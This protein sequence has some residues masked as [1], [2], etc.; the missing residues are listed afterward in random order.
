MPR[1]AHAIIVFVMKTDRLEVKICGLTR[2]EDVAVAVESG[3]DYLGLIRAAS[4]RA[5]PTSQLAAL[6]AAAQTPVQ[7][8]T[9]KQATAVLL[10]VDAPL[11]T[12]REEL[13]LSGAR[14]VQLH[15]NE[16][17]EL[18]AKLREAAPEVTRI[19][20]LAFDGHCSLEAFSQVARAYVEVA[21]VVLVDA[22]KGGE[23]PGS[24]AL[25]AAAQTLVALGGFRVWLAGGL[26][27]ENLSQ[28]VKNGTVHGV[29]VAR[30]VETEPGKKSADAIQKFITT[31]RGI[32]PANFSSLM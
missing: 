5:A 12:I 9:H 8:P 16:P 13:T 6:V 19:K 28:V 21:D 2:I 20:A 31:A 7:S 23:N 18:L 14:G 17:P 10:Y 4:R 27:P 11:E 1:Q 15:G 24:E 3:A 29:D 26:T 25:L 32:E 22:P 30:G